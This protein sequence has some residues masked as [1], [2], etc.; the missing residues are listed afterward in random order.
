[1]S[2]Y[3]KLFQTTAQ[4]VDHE[5]NNYLEPYVSLTLHDTTYSATLGGGGEVLKK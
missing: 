3:I 5:T 1:M 2:E 4:R